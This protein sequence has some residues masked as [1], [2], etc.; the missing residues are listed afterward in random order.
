MLAITKRD[1]IFSL[2]AL[3]VVIVAVY[4]W[5]FGMGLHKDCNAYSEH[6]EQLGSEE[7]LMAQQAS[8]DNQLARARRE[9][10]AFKEQS[11]AEAAGAGAGGAC[12]GA[13]VCGVKAGEV[14]GNVAC[15]VC[16]A[17]SDVSGARI[18]A[19]RA[20][21]ASHDIRLVSAE[22]ISN[23]GERIANTRSSKLEEELDFV[24]VANASFSGN[25]PAAV[26]LKQYRGCQR[27]A[28]S[29]EASFGELK[30]MLKSCEE[31]ALPL[32]IEAISMPSVPMGGEKRIWCLQIVL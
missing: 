4:A 17:F 27:W 10:A 21:L 23:G 22:S 11:G 8:L 25:T 28:F 31:E 3:P 14:C 16:G 26:L 1:K 24:P 9:L 19:F 2:F 20:L 7:E 29:V 18:N 6:I 12:E 13:Q 32:V 5:I 30:A 15:R